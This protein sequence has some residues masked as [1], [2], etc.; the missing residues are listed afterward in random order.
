MKDKTVFVII[1]AILAVI[2]VLALL[3]M[4]I[5][6]GK[7][8]LLFNLN[9]SDNVI[10]LTNSLVALGTIFL[11]FATFYSLFNAKTEEDKK[12]KALLS[13]FN[14]EHLG[15]IKE[16]C[17]RQ[18]LGEINDKYFNYPSFEIKENQGLDEKSLQQEFDR[19]RHPYDR[20]FIFGYNYNEIVN[21]NLYKDL[22]NHK[23]TIGIPDD[24]KNILNLIIKNYPKYLE[25][26]IKLIIKNKI[27]RRV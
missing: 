11:A 25:N 4:L 21:N 15:D 14:A 20:E 8:I 2:L 22:Q 19:P 18:I 26:I 27:V 3:V 1:E 17:L 6:L 10:I 13:Q 16:Y 7:S 12:Q 5:Y 9:D 23:I 24:F